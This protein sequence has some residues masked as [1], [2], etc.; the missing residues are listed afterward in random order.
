MQFHY[1]ALLLLLLSKCFISFIIHNTD[2]I[3][4]LTFDIG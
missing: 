1:N 3:Q 2:K 4:S